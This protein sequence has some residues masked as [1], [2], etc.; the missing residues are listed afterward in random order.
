[1]SNTKR[2][3]HGGGGGEKDGNSK[4]A[5]VDPPEESISEN[6]LKR[7][8][9]EAVAAQLPRL[10]LETSK[11]VSEQLA[12]QNEARSLTSFSQ[13]MRAIRQKQEELATETKAAAIKGESKYLLFQTSQYR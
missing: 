4:H 1:M 3:A 6:D 5:R 10:I 13:E 2:G 12:E 7:I 11:V 8:M 9:S